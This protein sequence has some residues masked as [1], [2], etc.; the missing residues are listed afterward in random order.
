MTNVE[1]LKSALYDNIGSRKILT[2]PKTENFGLEI[3]LE[4]LNFN[5]TERRVKLLDERFICKSDKSLDDFGV[6][7][8]TPVMRNQKE[9]LLLLRKLAT[10]LTDLGPRFDDCSFQVNFDDKFTV[11][12]RIEFFKLYCYYEK[13][14]YIFSKGYDPK[15]RINIDLYAN[16]VYNDFIF[17]FKKFIDCPELTLTQF[18]DMKMYGLNIKSDK[19]ILEFRTP[20]GTTNY[21]LWVNYITTFYYLLATIKRGNY[22]KE[23]VNDFIVNYNKYIDESFSLW[24]HDFD[25]DIDQC[26]Q[27]A[28]LIF[29]DELDKIHFLKQIISTKQKEAKQ[30]IYK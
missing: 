19:K 27:F 12:E 22:D 9:D 11:D 1:L 4:G 5:K 28:N 26:I 21:D 24:K 16:L 17:E 29:T 15:L 7:V 30:Y 14:I 13:L 6:E 23:R 10:S 20:N 25:I 2:I 8:V 3:E 18:E